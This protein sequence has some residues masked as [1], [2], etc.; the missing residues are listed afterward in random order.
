MYPNYSKGTTFVE[1]F[2]F[3]CFIFTLLQISD[4][5]SV[6]LFKFNGP[7]DLTEPSSAEKVEEDYS[8]SNNECVDTTDFIIKSVHDKVRSNF[9]CHLCSYISVQSGSLKIHIKAVHDKVRDF[10]CQICSY[11]SAQ[12]AMLE[13]HIKTVHDKV[14]DFKCHL[15]T[16]SSADTS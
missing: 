10:K 2:N 6:D 12:K 9:Q 8:I 14:R 15:C 1:S 16:L 3:V 4:V 7:N 11:S 5:H 13:R